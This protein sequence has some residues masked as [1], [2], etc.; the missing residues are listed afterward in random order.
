M[1]AAQEE[2]FTRVKNDAAFPR[3]SIAY[4]LAH[5]GIQLTN[6]D[7]IVFY[8]KPFLKFE[9]LLETFLSF[10]PYG[11]KIFLKAMPIWLKEKLY[12]KKMLIK[13]LKTIDEEWQPGE[14]Q[15]LFCKHHQSHA[16]SAFYPS[17]FSSAIILTVDGVG[18]WETT[19]VSVGKDRHIQPVN[20]IVFPHSLGLLYSAFTYHLG[21]K[22]NCD[23]YKVMGLAPYGKPVYKDVILDKLVDVKADGSFQL[24]MKYFNYATG[25]TMTSKHF[26]KLFNIQRRLS[27]EPLTEQHMNIAASIQAAA[28]NIMLKITSALYKK[29]RI[30]NLC[31]AGGVAL[32]C[33]IN[34]KILKQSG[35]KNVWIQPAAGDAGGALGAAYAVYHQ[36]L[37]NPRTDVG[38]DKM[39]SCLLGPAFDDKQVLEAL[40]EAGIAFER[41]EK[42]QLYAIVANEIA[43]G[44]VVGYFN[45]RMEFGPRA[46]GARSILADARNPEMQSLLNQKIKFRE[47]FRPFA[48]AVMEEFADEFFDLGVKSPYMLM[49]GEVKDEKKIKPQ[50]QSASNIP[51]LNH[52]R[53][54]IPAVTHVDYSAR[55]QTVNPVDHP[56]FYQVIKAFYNL[57]GC[58]MVINTS[59][60]RMD[61]PIVCS[62]QDAIKC[63]FGTGIDI[64]VINEFLIR[65]PVP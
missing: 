27:E 17:P 58:P 23:E 29:Y 28:E 60:N 42:Q 1:A 15:L 45:G 21:F 53:S 62:P 2:R 38:N 20:H 39:K 31:L 48:P 16:A 3:N 56:D 47:S 6:V 43:K 57:T 4:C 8:E 49:V 33:V 26:D 22:V 18:E 46:L 14:R 44:R 7:H 40:N 5:A 10:A 32:N 65:K 11:I 34:T 61:E 55:L 59:F 19:S 30:D 51:M 54:I 36:Y 63:F 9:R 25:L 64:L 13:A 24:N 41:F 37:G 12:F 35:F 50:Q 52:V